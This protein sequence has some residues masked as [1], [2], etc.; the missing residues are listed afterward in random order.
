MKLPHKE[1]ENHT[2]CPS[3]SVVPQVPVFRQDTFVLSHGF[4]GQLS[5]DPC[6]FDGSAIFSCSKPC[7]LTLESRIS[8]PR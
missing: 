5:H 1:M 3:N 7:V 6:I 2:K 8:K 4:V